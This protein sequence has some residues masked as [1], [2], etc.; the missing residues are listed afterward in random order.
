MFNFKWCKLSSD[1]QSDGGYRMI[2]SEEGVE[3]V[4][5][6]V[7]LINDD[8]PPKLVALDGDVFVYDDSSIRG[9]VTDSL[10]EIDIKGSFKGFFKE[11]LEFIMFYKDGRSGLN[12][13]LSKTDHGWVGYWT[14]LVGRSKKV[15]REC[16]VVFTDF[17]KFNSM[18]D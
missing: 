1:W 5:I 6:V 2:E 8:D 7:T 11:E 9:G 13:K 15:K 14:A 16:T 10:G 12:C 18:R 17:N 3:R 4:R